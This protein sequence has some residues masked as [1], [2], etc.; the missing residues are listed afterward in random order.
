MCG[1]VSLLRKQRKER[2]VVRTKWDPKY[3]TLFPTHLELPDRD[4]DLLGDANVE[5]PSAV[6]ACKLI[7]I[8]SSANR[9]SSLRCFFSCHPCCPFLFRFCIRAPSGVL[10]ISS[11]LI[12]VSGSQVHRG[13]TIRGQCARWPC[14]NSNT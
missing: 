1:P 14:A 7:R 6:P 2:D 11:L 5:F 4:H 8:R 9:S 3:E 10:A 13:Y 12:Y